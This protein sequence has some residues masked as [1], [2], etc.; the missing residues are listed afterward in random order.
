MM[1]WAAVA[2][3]LLATAAAHADA[4][5][6]EI[7]GKVLESDPWGLSDA[8]ISARALLTDKRGATSELTFSARSRR[9][10]P[11]LSK[12]LVRFSA[13]ADLAGAGFLLVQKK[14]DDDD[15]YLFMPDLKRSRRIAGDLRSTSFMGTD[16]S[17]AD[18]DRRDLREAEGKLLADETVGKFPCYHLDVTPRRADAPYARIELWVRKDNFLPL[19]QQMYDKANVLVKTLGIDEVRRVSGAWFITKSHMINHKDNH[20]TDLT[21][22]QV[23]PKHD[24]ADD[25]FTVRALE[26][27]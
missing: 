7:I 16:F 14:G 21:L 25:E 18:L 4:T 3:I 20:R 13:P 10:D 27:I 19:R 24:I 17:F 23:T 26:K 5:A 12:S 9:Y 8:E 15:R 6:P 22:E 2:A 1:K 11:P